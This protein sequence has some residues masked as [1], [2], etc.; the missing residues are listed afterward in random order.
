MKFSVKKG[1]F[2]KIIAG[3]DKGKTAQIISVDVA[4]GRVVIEG[5]DIAHAKKAVKARK[6]SDKSGII[7]MPKSI[8]VSNVMPVCAEC[9]KAT[10]VKHAIVDGKKVRICKCG[11]VLE[12]KKVKEEKKAKATVRKKV[13]KDDVVENA[14]VQV[15]TALDVASVSGTPAE[16]KKEI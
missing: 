9:G 3:N 1:D 10:R 15:E 5:K 8:D 14:D 12:T 11:A 4:S 16:E 13:K 6:A 7:T 2:V